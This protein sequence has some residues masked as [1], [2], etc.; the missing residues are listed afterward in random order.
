MEQR[1]AGSDNP[2][3]NYLAGRSW[4]CTD[5][6]SGAHHWVYDEKDKKFHCK[7]CN[8]S[9]RLPLSWAEWQSKHMRSTGPP[10]GHPLAEDYPRHG[11]KDSG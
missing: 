8:Q 9:K 3:I 5:S 10:Y 1:K 6:P 4:Q 2:Y 11:M 7:Y